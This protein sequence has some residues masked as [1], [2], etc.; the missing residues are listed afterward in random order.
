[1][2]HR[3]LDQQRCTPAAIDGVMQRGKWRD[4]ADLRRAA[5]H[6]MFLLD[7]VERV[8]RNHASDARARHHQFPI[9][10]VNAHRPA[11]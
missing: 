7:K 2:R 4:W 3:H 10:Y 5:V 6:D 8:C 1:M 11:S 9:H